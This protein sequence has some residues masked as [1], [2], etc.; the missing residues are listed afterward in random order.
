MWVEPQVAYRHVVQ[1]KRPAGQ[2]E[3]PYVVR[4]LLVDLPG[5][6]LEYNPPEF[7]VGEE[8]YQ[9]VFREDVLLHV[10]PVRVEGNQPTESPPGMVACLS[11]D[12]H[13]ALATLAFYLQEWEYIPYQEIFLGDAAAPL[14]DLELLAEVLEEPFDLG[15]LALQIEPAAQRELGIEVYGR[16]DLGLVLEEVPTPVIYLS[17]LAGY[18]P[19]LWGMEGAVELR[20]GKYGLALG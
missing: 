16:G 15:V 20:L 2:D 14:V 10:D 11:S 7:L 6:L 17:S 12:G 18:L 3:S 8:G 19:V 5:L 1:R 9:G 13:G 4:D